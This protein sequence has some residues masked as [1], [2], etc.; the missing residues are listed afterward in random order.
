MKV[1]L[2]SQDPHQTSSSP[3]CRVARNRVDI[4]RSGGKSRS[5]FATKRGGAFSPYTIRLPY[6]L[7]YGSFWVT[8][9]ACPAGSGF[10]FTKLIRLVR[11][12]YILERRGVV[13]GC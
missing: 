2:Q 13:C 3:F 7:G 5:R 1:T 10:P 9:L 8:L 6:L 11:I 4:L 12:E